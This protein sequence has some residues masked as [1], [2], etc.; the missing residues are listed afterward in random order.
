MSKIS[1]LL[2]Q[3]TDHYEILKTAGELGEIENIPTFVG[4]AYWTPPKTNLISLNPLQPLHV[5]Q[6]IQHIKYL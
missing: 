6:K 3:N 4:R 5:T 1:D 2:T